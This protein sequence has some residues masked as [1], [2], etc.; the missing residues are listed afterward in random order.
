M[1]LSRLGDDVGQ[2]QGL[3]KCSVDKYSLSRG[4]KR[5]AREFF[6]AKEE[7]DCL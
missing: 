2:S 5:K 1:S 4:T 7:A 6:L 3:M